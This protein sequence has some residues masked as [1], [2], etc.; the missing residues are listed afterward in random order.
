METT[1]GC[2]AMS[3]S[4]LY[5]LTPVYLYFSLC[6][7]SV[8]DL[9]KD[10]ATHWPFDLSMAHKALVAESAPVAHRSK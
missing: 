8:D 5:S 7:M 10:L 4:T 3:V 9:E 6:N 1:K 2:N